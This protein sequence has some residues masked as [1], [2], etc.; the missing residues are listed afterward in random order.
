ML[1]Q[2]RRSFKHLALGQAQQF[3]ATRIGQRLKPAG[4][5]KPAGLARQF[6]VHGADNA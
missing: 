3:I 6:D 1:G 4:N 2:R 5:R